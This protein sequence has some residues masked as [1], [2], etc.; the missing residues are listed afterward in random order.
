MA[1]PEVEPGV[2]KL[3]L[4][5]AWVGVMG[6]GGLIYRGLKGD[7]ETHRK[8]DRET[9]KALFEGQAG[10]KDDIADGFA[11]LN[12]TI[13]GMHVSLL[14]KINTKADKKGGQ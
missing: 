11:D 14:E 12:K 5:W 8:E 2:L 9:F 7:F 10:I 4:D 13:S 1:T 6:L 3:L